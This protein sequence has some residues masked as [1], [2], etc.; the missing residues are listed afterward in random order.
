V[1]RPRDPRL[2]RFD[3]FLRSRGLR[4]SARRGLVV[5]VFLTAPGRLSADE[6]WRAAQVRDRSIG[7][8]TVYRALRLLADAGL[9]RS[10]EGRGAAQYAPVEVGRNDRLICLDCGKTTELDLPEAD[11]LQER[12]ALRHGYSVDHRELQ[13]LGRCPACRRRRALARKGAAPRS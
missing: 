8:A 9:A 6:L 11:L 4:H 5:E 3:E 2:V 13:L 12:V 1:G 7:A 10:C